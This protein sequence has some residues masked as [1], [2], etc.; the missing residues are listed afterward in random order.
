MKTEVISAGLSALLASLIVVPLVRKWAL[1][2]GVMDVPNERSSHTIPTPRTGGVGVVLGSMVGFFVGL[3]GATPIPTEVWSLVAIIICLAAV[4]LSDDIWQLS[5][6]RRMLLYLLGAFLLALLSYR[7]AE[8]AFPFAD[9]IGLGVGGGLVFTSLFV[10]WYTNLFNF[11]DGIDGIAA[12]AAIVTC[13]ALTYLFGREGNLPLVVVSISLTAATSGFLVY[14][15]SPASIFMGDVGS[16][17]LGAACAALTAAAIELGYVSII[18]GT[19]LMFPFVFDATFTLF[20][21]ALRKE[22]VWLPHRTHIYQQ[23]C[24]LGFTHRAVSG[25]YTGGAA[26]FAVL[27]VCYD[28]LSSALQ[29]LIALVALAAGAICGSVVLKRRKALQHVS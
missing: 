3:S 15:Y 13:G 23:M 2:G 26:C 20:R 19:L 7:I 21:R 8:L 22:K 9:P 1:R 24:D 18:A 29:A 4:G 28:S 6:A 12:G 5:A 10:G 25:I 11:M 17:F 27:G 14:N 16:V